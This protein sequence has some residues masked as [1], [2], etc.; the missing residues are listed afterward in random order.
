LLLIGEWGLYS[1]LDD[2]LD[3]TME[4]AV[5]NYFKFMV[6]FGTHAL[7]LGITIVAEQLPVVIKDTG[8]FTNVSDVLFPVSGFDT[9]TEHPCCSIQPLLQIPVGEQQSDKDSKELGIKMMDVIFEVA[10]GARYMFTN[11]EVGWSD[12]D[13]DDLVGQMEHEFR[14]ARGLLI[15][16]MMLHA[17]KI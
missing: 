5:P 3:L 10:A 16:Y 15:Q 7:G 8:K 1:V 13:Y 17:T 6:G 14:T 9:S 2:D 4:Q 12:D 11:P